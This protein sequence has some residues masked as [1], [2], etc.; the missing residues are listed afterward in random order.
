MLSPTAVPTPADDDFPGWLRVNGFGPVD[1]GS[2]LVAAQEL[3]APRFGAPDEIVD[4]PDCGLTIAGWDDFSIA[5]AADR[6]VGWFYS[7]STPAL[8]SPSGV[9][10]GTTTADL[11]EIYAGVDISET[12]LGTEFFFEVPAG[13]IGGFFTPDGQQVSELYAGQNCFFR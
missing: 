1:F 11:R 3:I 9:T 7:S 8:E 12:T 13:F 4:N 5:F 6:L 10:P 2:D